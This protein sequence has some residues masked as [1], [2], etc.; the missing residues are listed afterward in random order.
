MLMCFV[1]CARLV[2]TTNHIM[3]GFGSRIPGTNTVSIFGGPS[4][5]V[6]PGT[7]FVTFPGGGMGSVIPGTNTV[8]ITYM[9]SSVPLKKKKK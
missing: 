9:P 7:N 8:N 5:S 3:S 1:N 2:I 4:G 6:V